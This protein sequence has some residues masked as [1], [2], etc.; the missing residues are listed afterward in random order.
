MPERGEWLVLAAT[1]A[2]VAVFG[3]LFTRAGNAEFLWYVATMLVLIGLVALGQRSA[4]FPPALLWALSL[5]G[6]AHM[7]SGGVPVGGSVLYAHIVL[8]LWV[9]GE[10]AFLRYDQIVHF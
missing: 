4:R 8:P 10:Y 5:W 3:V 6:L 2:Y 7:A 9:D 1:L